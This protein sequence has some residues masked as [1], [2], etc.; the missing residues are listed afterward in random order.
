MGDWGFFLFSREIAQL[1]AFKATLT[2]ADEIRDVE[3]TIQLLKEKEAEQ[4]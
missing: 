2:N 1:E 3:K 4:K